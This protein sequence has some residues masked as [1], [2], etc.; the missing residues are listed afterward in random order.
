MNPLKLLVDE[1]LSPQIAVTLRAEGFDVVHVRDRGLNAASDRELF[2]RAFVEDRLVVTSNVGDFERLA[3]TCQLHA[4]LV[5]I[6]DGTLA[7][8]E[9]LRVVRA[10][11][12]VMEADRAAGRDM[13]NRV[14]RIWADGQHKLQPL[15]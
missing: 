8:D 1:N 11:L 6:E 3:R 13:V 9:Q 15:P 12:T 10:A 2:D 4:G 14:L 5:L 7:R